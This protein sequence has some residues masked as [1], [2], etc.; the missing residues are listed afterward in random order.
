MKQKTRF[1]ILEMSVSAIDP[2]MA[3]MGRYIGL[4]KAVSVDH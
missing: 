3:A 1:K 2:S 4:K